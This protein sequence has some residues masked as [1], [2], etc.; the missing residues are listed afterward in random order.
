MLVALLAGAL[1][2]P[3]PALAAR[4]ADDAAALARQAR[5]LEAEGKLDLAAALAREA[6]V[7]SPEDPAL[8]LLLGDVEFAREA[9]SDALAAYDRW[10]TLLPMRARV[11]T[12][13]ER[14]ESRRAHC[15]E[16]LR[17]ALAVTVDLPADCAVDD[18]PPQ[19]L[20]AGLRVE[21]RVAPGEH[22]LRCVA[23]DVP[24]VELALP[25]K[26][27]EIVVVTVTLTPP[28]PPPPPP[29]E[30]PEPPPPEEPPPPPP[31][32]R[33]Q[34]DGPGWI[35]R[36]DEGAPQASDAN[37]IV[38]FTPAP[39]EHL[40]GCRRHLFVP[41]Q[42]RFTVA[43]GEEHTIA[44]PSAPEE[45]PVAAPRP[46]VVLPR[47]AFEW[48][49]GGGW[50]PGYGGFGIAAGARVGPIGVLLGSGLLPLAVTGSWSFTPG[51]TGPFVSAGYQRIGRGLF[52]GGS[53]VTTHAAFGSLGFDVR[54][55][56]HLSLRI[57]MGASY[58]LEAGAT[59]PLAVELAA[60]YVP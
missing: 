50:G 13:W 30:L 20:A 38:E 31:R 51:E 9:C 17:T 44:V 11:T 14:V 15:R 1:A 56:P 47:P 26:A 10:R 29:E 52:V 54:V 6:L 19:A 35:C 46:V 57:G 24:P 45:P 18:G 3:S 39:G 34:T 43:A 41:Y 27:G 4:P 33:V 55:I 48:M 28:P 25:V 5:R 37:G 12:E 21:L 32:V 8:H 2:L 16:L 59:G 58:G 36:L 42:E 49:I 7:L 23:A 40:L 22:R 60:F 53:T